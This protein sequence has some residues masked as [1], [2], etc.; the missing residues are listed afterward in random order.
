MNDKCNS[1]APRRTSASSTTRL[2]PSHRRQR[3][4]KL[5][6]NAISGLTV[7]AIT[8]AVV[9]AVF[10]REAPVAK[11][12]G[13]IVNLV[14]QGTYEFVVTEQGEIENSSNIELKC[15]VKSRNSSGVT[16]LE[17]VPEGTVVQKGDLLVRLDSSALDLE[18]VQQ[19]ITCNTSESLV[20]QARNTLE[21]AQISR[22]EYLEGTFKQEEKLILA[23]VFV[24]EQNLRSAQLALES[25]QRLAAK[26]IVNPLQLEGA[27]FA[28]DKARNE[29]EA[30]QTKLEVIRKYTREKMLKQF[31]SDIATSEAKLSAEENSYQLELDKLKDIERQ[32]LGCTILAPS[33]GQVVYANKFSSG[34]S[35]SNAEFVVEAGATVREQQP[36]IRLPDSNL[37][38]VKA[39]INE[40]RITLVR[41]GMPVT[42]RVDAISDSLLQ[43]EV[44]KVNQYAE[45]GGWSSGNV[46]KYAAFVRIIDPPASIRSGMNA[47]VRIHVERRP[48]AIQVPVQALAEVKGHYF[49]LVKNGE[50][51]ETREVEIGSTNDKTAVI[52]SGLQKDEQVVMN[53]RGY[54][55]YLQLPAIADRELPAIANST[56][57]ANVTPAGL[58]G[59]GAGGPGSGGRPGM[60]GG[61]PGAV[62]P[63]AGGPPGPGGPGGA[64]GPGGERRG[65]PN[66]A[67]IVTRVMQND[68]DADGKI[69][70][71]EMAAMDDRTR[72]MLTAA[73]TN[74]DGFVDKTEVLIAAAAVVQKIKAMGGVGGGGQ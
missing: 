22:I 48:D 52:N 58:P 37:M 56:P 28:V 72:E 40:S 74:N 17:V 68:T 7:L 34:R 14:S 10:L 73:D 16:I 19:Q 8:G 32:V 66:A 5:L 38:H 4:G 54:P 70:E 1:G 36:I 33:G 47:E 61:P 15:E 9:W 50:N 24:A 46:K 42:I 2:F 49:C 69:S 55:N 12:S 25:A 43:G 67:M 26:N 57:G 59:S 39:L 62:G 18:R 65:P 6:F 35:G 29:L 71:S 23:E 51:Y 13:P 41:P 45:P 20:I 63:G 64:G 27:Q 30:A 31:D 11:G 3:R 44:T 21:A 53:P 60:A